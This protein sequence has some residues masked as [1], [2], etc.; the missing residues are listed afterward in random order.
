[1][2]SQQREKLIYLIYNKGIALKEL[3][4][5]EKTNSRRFRLF[6][7]YM[8]SDLTPFDPQEAFLGRQAGRFRQETKTWWR[9]TEE[10]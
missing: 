5:N 3:Y 4:T 7:I 2:L 6:C 10:I 1:M 9:N 8:K